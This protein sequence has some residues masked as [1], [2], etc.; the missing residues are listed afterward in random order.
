MIVIVPSHLTAVTTS[1]GSWHL[2]G[3]PFEA[4][5]TICK[6]CLV[7]E[8][9][10]EVTAIGIPENLGIRRSVEM[11]LLPDVLL[12]LRRPF[13]A[14]HRGH[15]VLGSLSLCYL[16]LAECQAHS[17]VSPRGEWWK[18]WLVCAMKYPCPWKQAGGHWVCECEWHL[19]AQE[20]DTGW[21]PCWQKGLLVRKTFWKT[22]FP[23]SV[24]LF[25][26]SSSNLSLPHFK[27]CN[28][29][30]VNAGF[31]NREVQS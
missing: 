17:R 14:W 27:V 26:K 24:C 31:V 25:S 8:L 22:L 23:L 13:C 19:S 6:L 1:L 18:R 21:E 29:A 15:K 30:L 28:Q 4:V 12:W 9:S 20:A 3:L 2:L 11:P 16:H 5:S 7:A 10:G